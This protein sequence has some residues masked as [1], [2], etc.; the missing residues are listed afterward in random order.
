MDNDPIEDASARAKALGRKGAIPPGFDDW[1]AR[2]VDREVARRFFDAADA[3]DALRGALAPPAPPVDDRRAPG[4]LLRD[5][6]QERVQMLC[7]ALNEA[8]RRGAVHARILIGTQLLGGV[9]F[10]PDEIAPILASHDVASRTASA[11]VAR[12]WS[13]EQAGNRPGALED[14]QQAVAL[15]PGS[16]AAHYVLGVLHLRDLDFA[17]ALPAFDRAVALLPHAAGFLRE[18]ARCLHA[19]GQY[20]RALADRTAV[21][22]LDPERAEAWTARALVHLARRDGASAERDLTEAL[23]R[24]PAA[25]DALRLRATL[26]AE[27]GD[28]AGALGDLDV[29]LARGADDGAAWF[30]RARVMRALGDA[31]AAVDAL[32]RAVGCG[33]ALAAMEL[34]ALG[35]GA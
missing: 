3:I 31:R 12:A 22:A 35:L 27:R 28:L 21:L 14:A 1:F 5:P 23:R 9:G 11:H 29:V 32:R 30:E 7:L 33:H 34:Q 18:R 8:E 19:M 25:M 16:A 10:T 20:D 17:G 2:C 4:P 24:E 26:R 13:C 6:R 15:A